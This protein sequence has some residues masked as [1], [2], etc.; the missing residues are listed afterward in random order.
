MKDIAFYKA[1]SYVLYEKE[2]LFSKSASHLVMLFSLHEG[3][4]CFMRCLAKKDK[5]KFSFK[6]ICLPNNQ[7]RIENVIVSNITS[8]ILFEKRILEKVW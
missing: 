1:S 8:K 2:G 3:G 7:K 6:S 4:H 5:Y